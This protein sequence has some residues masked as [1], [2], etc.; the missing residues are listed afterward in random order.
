M[1]F[2]PRTNCQQPNR[3]LQLA[4]GEAP[5]R[6][7]DFTVTSLSLSRTEAAITVKPFTVTVTATFN[8]CHSCEREPRYQ[9]GVDSQSACSRRGRRASKGARFPKLNVTY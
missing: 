2:A 9:S 6:Q 1:V 3:G 5:D 7:S 8:A 4:P